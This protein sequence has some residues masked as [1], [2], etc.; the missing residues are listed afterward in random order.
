MTSLRKR[1]RTDE[2]PPEHVPAPVVEEVKAAAPSERTAA[3]DPPAADAP[4]P[5]KP[6]PEMAKRLQEMDAAQERVRHL[7]AEI[8]QRAQDAR[9]HIAHQLQQ[10]Q[11]QQPQ[12]PQQVDVEVIIENA[13]LPE[14]AKAWLRQHPDYVLDPALNARMQ[15]MHHVAEYQ[16]GEQF[17]D[18]YFARLE[19]LLG[20]QPATNGHDEVPPMSEPSPPAQRRQISVPQFAS[21]RPAPPAPAPRPQHEQ[22]VPPASAPPHREVP[23]YRSGRRMSQQTVRLSADQRQIAHAARPDLPREQAE[24]LYAQNVQ[25]LER[26]KAAGLLQGDG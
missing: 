3:A 25:R 16:A 8:A 11:E 26:L 20:L 4:D 18:A 6:V 23:S 13:P 9:V 21:E 14:N 12:E 17:T 15:K 2:L 22:H 7:E 1:H 24:A 5:N 19:E 10:P